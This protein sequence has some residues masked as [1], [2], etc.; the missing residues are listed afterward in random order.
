MKQL[1][2][3]KKNLEI[4]TN[5]VHNQ[6]LNFLFCIFIHALNCSNSESP[7]ERLSPVG[8]SGGSLVTATGTGRGSEERPPLPCV[9]ATQDEVGGGE[10]LLVGGE[11]LAEQVVVPVRGICKEGAGEGPGFVGRL[12]ASAKT[13]FY[14]IK[15]RLVLDPGKGVC[16]DPRGRDATLGEGEPR[17]PVRDN[18]RQLSLDRGG[19][20][21]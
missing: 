5:I 12:E 4:N 7:N 16:T 13:I 14:S 1:I 19:E 10:H 2:L 17:P 15:K 21:T 6:L 3:R 8:G 20:K 9:L 11:V 18:E